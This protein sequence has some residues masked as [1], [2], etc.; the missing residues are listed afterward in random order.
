MFGFLFIRVTIV[1][2]A[3]GALVESTNLVLLLQA[4]QAIEETATYLKEYLEV[5]ETFHDQEEMFEP[6]RHLDSAVTP[7]RR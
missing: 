2:L 3:R 1:K 6:K 5:A 7:L 4:K